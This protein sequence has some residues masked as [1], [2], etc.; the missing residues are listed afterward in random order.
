MGSGAAAVVDVAIVAIDIPI[1]AIVVAITILGLVIL[2]IFDIVISF[3]LMISTMIRRSTCPFTLVSIA[4]PIFK[5][6]FIL[7]LL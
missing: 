1:I 5:L 4:H 2:V 6:S 7:I 3:V